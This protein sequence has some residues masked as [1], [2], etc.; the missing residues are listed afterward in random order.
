MRPAPIAI[1]GLATRFP[2]DLN[3]PDETWAALLEG[4]DFVT[5][6]DVRDITHPAMR[7]RILLRAEA[8]I[9]GLSVDSLISALLDRVPAP[10]N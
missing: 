1:V 9:E 3:T 7:H 5:P 2:G 4:R 10:R 6:D 8:E